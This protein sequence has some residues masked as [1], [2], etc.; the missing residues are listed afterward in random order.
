VHCESRVAVA[1]AWG[2]FWNSERIMSAVGSQYQ[3]TG[4]GQKAEKTQCRYSELSSVR[5]RVGL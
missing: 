4:E 5:N 3:R 1:V 2:Q